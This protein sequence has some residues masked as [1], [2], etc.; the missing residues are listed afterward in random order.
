MHSIRPDEY[1]KEVGKEV[2]AIEERLGEEGLKLGMPGYGER[3]NE[4]IRALETKLKWRIEGKDRPALDPD[5]KRQKLADALTRA[6]M[7]NQRFWFLEEDP[8]THGHLGGAIEVDDDNRI[9]NLT[10]L[11]E[12]LAELH[13]VNGHYQRGNPIIPGGF[14]HPI[15]SLPPLD[16]APD[17]FTMSGHA[18]V[19]RRF[20][21]AL[22]QPP[23]VVQ[24]WPVEL[25]RASDEAYSQEYRLFRVLT[26]QE[27]MDWERSVYQREIITNQ[28]TKEQIV[29][30]TNLESFVPLPDLVPRTEI[31][32]AK[33][34][35]LFIL[36][37]DA[38][39]ERVLRAGCHG[40][41]FEEPET[42]G[43]WGYEPRCI[44]TADKVSVKDAHLGLNLDLE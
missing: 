28:R 35:P 1:A 34:Y 4:L 6:G 41:T 19:S 26:I 24:Y 44:R 13:Y 29:R 36:I 43:A 17:Y 23:D 2:N 33:E 16:F 42:C 9:V 31:F 18:F 11:A 7:A 40:V 15:L 5:S 21:E 10:E 12:A 37:T 39:A 14:M 22:A 3:A 32:R 20:R 25:K 30:I 8:E 27:A 38:V